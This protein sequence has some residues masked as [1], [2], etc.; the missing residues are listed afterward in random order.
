MNF[1][2]IRQKTNYFKFPRYVQLSSKE[3]RF[4]ARAQYGCLAGFQLQGKNHTLLCSIQG[5]WLGEVPKCNEIKI[6]STTT[7]T[8]T[9]TLPPPP[10]ITI[11][12]TNR[13]T[14]SGNPIDSSLPNTHYAS[15][16]TSLDEYGT[17]RNRFETLWSKIPLS[18]SS[19]K[20]SNSSPSS[21]FTTTEQPTTQ[22]STN[23]NL[24]KIKPI[25]S[26][27]KPSSSNT[28]STAPPPS[29]TGY[30][31]NSNT[32]GNKKINHSAS[33]KNS[34][35]HNKLPTIVTKNSD[36]DG[37]NSLSRKST[38]PKAKF[39]IVGIIALAI[40]GSFVFLAAIITIV[41]IVFRR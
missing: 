11:D 25:S 4:G 5:Y 27:A 26:T 17:T 34:N 1:L 18:T 30:N 21:I 23:N 6:S 28:F 12:L 33:N 16:R 31:L 13:F 22:R 2:K 9:T 24:N 20:Q 32:N 29:T 36:K 10:A 14:S 37:I 40:F 19:A 35:Y 7:T 8:T 15:N 41:I 3:T 39:N 38:S